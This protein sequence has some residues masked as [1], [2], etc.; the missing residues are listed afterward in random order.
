MRAG[1]ERRW[2]GPPPPG[3]KPPLELLWCRWGR[4]HLQLRLTATA[5]APFSHKGRRSKR[6]AP[7]HSSPLTWSMARACAW[8]WGGMAFWH[9]PAP[10]CLTGSVAA[11]PAPA[12]TL[13]PLP[14]LL[15]V[16]SARNSS[17][18]CS[19]ATSAAT[20]LQ[21]HERVHVCLLWACDAVCQPR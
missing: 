5:S 13:L 21:M 6:P 17:V 16:K 8:F 2:R 10:G 15:L 7:A 1:R 20:P 4:A 14:L 18:A 11:A 3:A 12:P 19:C 9:C